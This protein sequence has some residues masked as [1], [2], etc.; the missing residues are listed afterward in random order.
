MADVTVEMG[1]PICWADT[2]DYSSTA[3]GISRTHQIDLTS[4][5]DGAARQGAKAD[6]T[7]NRAGSY[8]VKACIEPGV[9]PVAGT[10]VEFYWSSSFST[11]AGTGNDGG[12]SVTG[13]DAAWAPGGGAEADV[14][15]FKRQLIFLGSM[16]M[17]ADAIPQVAL[18]RSRFFPPARYGQPVLKNDCGQAFIADAVKMYV[19]LIPNVD[20]VAA[21]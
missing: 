19:A 20:D 3:S 15:E 14:D 21:S 9:A 2:T 17:T 8:A 6:L 4:L 10:R 18:L 16:A 7:A 11:T 1:T 12:T 13:A 5:A